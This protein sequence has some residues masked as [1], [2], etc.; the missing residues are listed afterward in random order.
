MKNTRLGILRRSRG[1][2]LE[3]VAALMGSSKPQ[4]C[5]FETGRYPTAANDYKRRYAKAVRSSLPHVTAL[6]AEVSGLPAGRKS[7]TPK[8]VI[9]S[10][11]A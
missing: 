9:D 10:Q 11:A 1:L 8:K 7:V 5:A 2:T 3:A 6:H 4:V